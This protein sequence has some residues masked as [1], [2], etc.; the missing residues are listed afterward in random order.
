M[1]VQ[2]PGKVDTDLRPQEPRSK[3]D[4][5]NCQQN[6]EAGLLTVA[7]RSVIF[8][9]L[10]RL[11]DVDGSP[12]AEV[13]GTASPTA[14]E[15]SNKVETIAAVIDSIA[16]TIGPPALVG[17]TE[18]SSKALAK[19]IAQR[20]SATS[21][22]DVD[23][24]AKDQYGFSLSALNISLLYDPALFTAVTTLRSHVV[25]L[26]FDTRDVLEV[27]LARV[28]ATPFT[29]L[30]NHWPSRLNPEGPVKRVAAGYYVAGL[31]YTSLRYTVSELW[32]VGSK[33]IRMPTDAALVERAGLPLIA[34]GD[35]NDEP[36][37]PS[38]EALRS[39][40]DTRTVLDESL[41]GGGDVRARFRKYQASPPS[42]LNPFWRLAVGDIGSYYRSP[43]W[44][45]YDQILLSRGLLK[46]SAADT[47]FFVPDTATIHSTP[48]AVRRDGSTVRLTN[49][50]GKPASF[51]AATGQGCSDHFAIAVGI[52]F[53]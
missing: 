9:N 13:L 28:N 12:V 27:V 3:T 38:L 32:D 52:E 1:D 6:A 23:S 8:W 14:A 51:E 47:T 4:L 46:T 25:D 35:F 39:T 21:L 34:M 48:T 49:N 11:F 33:R 15:L 2:R 19:R 37:D 17:L 22:V 18:I 10:E 7:I 44:R 20:V 40:P 29:V 24:Q 31:V 36:F 43:R 41:T 5:S 53:P 45:T 16:G 50:G 30:L 26:T 42:L